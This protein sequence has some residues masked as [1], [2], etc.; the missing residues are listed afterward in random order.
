MTQYR[1]SRSLV[2]LGVYA[3][4]IACAPPPASDTPV[5]PNR[6]DAES[7]RTAVQ[8]ITSVIVYDIFSPPQASRV[9]SYSSVAAYEVLRQSDTTYRSLAGQL[10]GL[11][12]VPA[13]VVGGTYS[14]PLASVH[15][16]MT[17]GKQLTFSRQKL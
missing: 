2:S 13:R 11:T 5:A 12:P 17:V 3:L 1:W 6:S 4:A 16:L 9:Y 7:L 14:L 8:D 10:R 15:A